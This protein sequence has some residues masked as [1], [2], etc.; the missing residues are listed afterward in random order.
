MF[1]DI[2]KLFRDR[3]RNKK[4]LEGVEPDDLWA[5]ISQGIESTPPSTGLG[6]KKWGL[7]LVLFIIIGG[8]AYFY[9]LQKETVLLKDNSQKVT[10]AGQQSISDF[11]EN[12]KYNHQQLTPLAIGEEAVLKQS[13][14]NS[15]SSNSG[16]KE[17]NNGNQPFL[18]E[19]ERTPIEQPQQSST[20]TKRPTPALSETKTWMAATDLPTKEV[21]SLAVKKA[22]IQDSMDAVA[23]ISSLLLS[24][25]NI[26]PLEINN[27]SYQPP[28]AAAVNTFKPSMKFSFLSGVNTMNVVAKET[29]D[30]TTFSQVLSKATSTNTGV[31]YGVRVT[32]LLTDK[33]AVS[34][35][36]EYEKTQTIFEFT[37]EKIEPVW[38]FNHLVSY[39]L[40]PVTGDTI[41]PQYGALVDQLTKRHVLHHNK[42]TGISI[43][44]EFGY[45]KTFGQWTLGL[46]L[47]V[48]YNFFL[49][50]R[51]RTITTEFD[52]YDFDDQAATDQ[53]FRKSFFAFQLN[54]YVDLRVNNRL[55]VRLNPVFKYNVHGMSDLYKTNQSSLLTGLRGGL[56]IRL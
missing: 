13:D 49:S 39:E 50:Q 46:N 53:P 5:G 26:P 56:V 54:P 3:L 6:Y 48:S 32:Y 2:E 20:F 45:R 40:D 52:I 34:S 31:S 25:F 36:L 41:N 15:A 29:G 14:K 27:L 19:K 7:I 22:A 17:K 9:L 51:G 24:A 42:F 30:S 33:I 35:G 11:H 1:S 23:P 21:S 55:S 8:A 47:G 28:L 12:K 4:S 38:V 43:P 18:K 10:F 37:T 16:L 44:L